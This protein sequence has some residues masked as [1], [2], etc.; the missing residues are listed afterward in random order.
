MTEERD[1]KESV[2]IIIGVIGH[3]GDMCWRDSPLGNRRSGGII[4]LRLPANSIG[5][6]PHCG[7][8][9]F[10]FEKGFDEISPGAAARSPLKTSTL[11]RFPGVPNPP[12]SSAAFP[13]AFWSRNKDLVGFF[14][15]F[16]LPSG[17]CLVFPVFSGFCRLFPD[18]FKPDIE[19]FS[20]LLSVQPSVA[21]VRVAA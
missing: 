21:T 8:Q 10:E 5:L 15:L 13:A 11:A 4:A 7:A 18:G 14:R 9:A 6:T 1:G 19:A 2:G 17:N 20:S 16:P 12:G 3:T